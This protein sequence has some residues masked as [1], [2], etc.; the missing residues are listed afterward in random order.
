M[1]AKFQRP[2]GASDAADG[3]VGEFRDSD[4]LGDE[5]LAKAQ[6]AEA[7][8]AA[9]VRGGEV[10]GD[11]DGEPRRNVRP[12]PRSSAGRGMEESSYANAVRGDRRS[13][14]PRPRAAEPP[15]P[16]RQGA[17]VSHSPR[18]AAH[19]RSASITTREKK[20]RR[21]LASRLIA[22][23]PS[24]KKSER[25]RRPPEPDQAEIVD[26]SRGSWRFVDL[27]CSFGLAAGL[28]Y[29]WIWPRGREVW[30]QADA[31]LFRFCN[32]AL[33][34]AGWRKGWAF[35]NHENAD[36]VGC[37]LF[38]S[39]LLYGTWRFGRPIRRCFISIGV[40][41]AVVLG[42]AS[43]TRAVLEFS[44]GSLCRPSPTVVNEDSLRLTALV[45]DVVC[46]D[47]SGACFPSDHCFIVLC[48]LLYL[49]YQ[50]NERSVKLCL[51]VALFYTLPRLVSGAHWFTD[52]AVGSTVLALITTAIL[53]AT[54]LHNS[55]V[56]RIDQFGFTV[57]RRVRSG[58]GKMAS[59]VTR[60]AKVP[61][62]PGEPS[63][64]MGTEV[65]S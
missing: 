22:M 65:G 52:Y 17:G 32:G 15:S 51:L 58:A 42:T 2:R 61:F 24:G 35:L 9:G 12:Q 25:R 30:D 31:F 23:R 33:S 11:R 20:A 14:E 59:R 46:K 47:I 57:R 37:V 34:F 44:N 16:R 29:S 18:Q 5:L 54:P 43:I 7:I 45:P 26:E 40:L 49:G 3:R 50:G 36:V 4:P 27:A 41:G 8:R 63:Q 19:D 38:A 62:R 6:V 64:R 10:A 21:G 1:N 39:L 56:N 48:I 13:D 28:A 60:S 53:M 55:L